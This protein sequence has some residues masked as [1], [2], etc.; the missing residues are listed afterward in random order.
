MA[1]LT[2]AV[3]TP[4]FWFASMGAR[5]GAGDPFARMCRERKG[6]PQPSPTRPGTRTVHQGAAI[7]GALGLRLDDSLPER[8]V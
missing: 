6:M 5:N 7:G 4:V 1:L 8:S 2:G 3:C